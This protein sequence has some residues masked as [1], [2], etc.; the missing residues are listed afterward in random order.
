MKLFKKSK[1]YLNIFKSSTREISSELRTL[2]YDFWLLMFRKRTSKEEEIFR[3]A[4]KEMKRWCIFILFV[5]LPIPTITYFVVVPKRFWPE[6]FLKIIR[7][8]EFKKKEL[9]KAPL[10]SS[11][12]N[13][14][15]N[16]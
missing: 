4:F 12:I 7:K 9:E 3:Y 16:A 15:S 5:P 14:N 8:A 1:E 11:E 10:K 13:Y 6:G 2:Q